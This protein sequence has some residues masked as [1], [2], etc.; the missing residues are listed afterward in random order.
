MFRMKKNG[1]PQKKSS[2][3][4]PLVA[5]Y[6]A[7]ADIARTSHLVTRV[8]HELQT[9]RI[10]NYTFVQAILIKTDSNRPFPTNNDMSYTCLMTT[11][12]CMELKR[13]IELRVRSDNVCVMQTLRAEN[14]QLSRQISELKE[15]NKKMSNK[16]R[17]F[18]ESEWKDL[19]EYVNLS[20]FK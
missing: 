15:A 16:L 17:L 14:E 6:F 2:V 5:A 10:C 11:D 13:E 7:D 3:C 18:E 9:A 19:V 1:I 12:I 4:M 20:S 8:T